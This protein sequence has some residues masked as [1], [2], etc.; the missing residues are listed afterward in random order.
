MTTSRLALQPQTPTGVRRQ[1]VPLLITAVAATLG[2]WM[3]AA[4]ASKQPLATSL[5]LVFLQTLLAAICFAVLLRSDR[6]P[7]IGPTVI[8][9]L[10]VHALMYYGP[11]NVMAALFADRRPPEL[12]LVIRVPSSPTE[13]YALSTVSA[14]LFLLGAVGGA[15]LPWRVLAPRSAV[16][17][18]GSGQRWA[19]IPGYRVATWSCVALLGVVV[20]ATAK[21]GLR[22][23]ATMLVEGVTATFTLLELVLWGGIFYFL[24]I[25]PLLAAAAV[26]QS[27]NRRA[28]R[29]AVG[30][31]VFATIASLAVLM[32]WRMRSTAM[33]SV[34]LP[35]ALL[36]HA[37]ILPL[38]KT[39]MPGAVAMVV[40]YAVV[41]FIRLSQVAGILAQS[42]GGSVNVGS[43]VEVMREGRGGSIV[44]K[45][46]FDLSYRA[47]G[48]EGV[49]AILHAQDQ[50]RV[51]LLM[52][53]STVAG[54]AQALPGSLRGRAGIPERIKTAPSH[55]GI[56]GES[57]WVTTFLAELALDFGPFALVAPAV[58]VGFLFG[59]VDCLLLILGNHSPGLQGLLI[60]RMPWLLTFI[61]MGSSAADLIAFFF[62]AN[63]GYTLLLVLISLCVGAPSGLRRPRGPQ[64]APLG[65]T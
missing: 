51:G 55:L 62:K 23:D 47:A 48:L 56:F 16:T 52:G 40:I 30:L 63:I 4:L 61:L 35:V 10:A 26:V 44:D 37:R 18:P 21:F 57:D 43:V 60:L 39:L 8:G 13:Y 45:A 22:F 12:E 20:V 25:A 54:F 3:A 14:L 53:R 6:R 2:A 59:L 1:R 49:A 64:S 9:I 32:V 50:N 38:R 11:S 58:L 31:L 24:P 15:A 36:V 7:S 46:M 19:W 29:S 34:V 42:T 41:T 5:P 33:I 17:S 65:A 28:R 27:P